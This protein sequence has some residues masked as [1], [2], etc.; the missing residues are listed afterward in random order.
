MY[1]FILQ[2]QQDSGLTLQEV[3][4]DIPHDTGAVVVYVMVAIFIALI[5]AGSRSKTPPAAG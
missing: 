2:A 4:R 1:A 5:W 3:I